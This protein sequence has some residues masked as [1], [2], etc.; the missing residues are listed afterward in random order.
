M[1]EWSLIINIYLDYFGKWP[2]N[3]RYADIFSG[4]CLKCNVIFLSYFNNFGLVV[5]SCCY[6]GV[7]RLITT[8]CCFLHASVSKKVRHKYKNRIFQCVTTSV[9]QPQEHLQWFWPLT[10]CSCVQMGIA[11]LTKKMASTTLNANFWLKY[12][13]MVQHFP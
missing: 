13:C 8:I 9:T 4:K 5:A 6:H 7:F 12:H 10:L 3:G 11:V 1:Y 2:F